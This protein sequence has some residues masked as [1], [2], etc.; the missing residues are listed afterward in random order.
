MR[1]VFLTA[2]AAALACAGCR[3]AAEVV[4]LDSPVRVQ[5]VETFAPAGRRLQLE[6]AT[7]REYGCINYS[8]ATRSDFWGKT[9]ALQFRGVEVPSICATAL[10]PART[11]VGLGVVPDDRYPLR[12]IANGTTVAGVLRVD[13]DSI[14]VTGAA[15]DW[16][17]IPRRVVRRVPTGAVWGLIGWGPEDRSAEADAFLAAMRDAGGEAIALA[18]GDYHQFRVTADGRLEWPGDAGYWAQRVFVLRWRGSRAG[19]ESLVRDHGD[20]LWIRVHG[21]RGE[22]WLS[23]TLRAER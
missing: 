17:R 20:P 13:A 19:I 10:G 9:I 1:R 12:L 7:E 2:V 16:T 14:V 11:I 4:P 18:A 3:E 6:C 23:W 5:V 15:G 21:D 22:N 8:L